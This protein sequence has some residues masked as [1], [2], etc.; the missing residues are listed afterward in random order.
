METIL[1]VF[2]RQALPMIWDFA[3]SAILSQSTG[4]FL[5]GLEVK[6]QA[7]A[8]APSSRNVGHVEAADARES[9]LPDESAAVWFTDP[10]YY[11][12]VPYSDLSDF[13]SFG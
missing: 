6:A 11:D 5:H 1:G 7:V 13:F 10:P 9:S 4:G 3:E 12:A 8:V 2:G